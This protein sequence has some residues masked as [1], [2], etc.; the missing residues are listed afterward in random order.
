MSVFF[1]QCK[2]SA[3]KYIRDHLAKS[4]NTGGA[5]FTIRIRVRKPLQGVLIRIRMKYFSKD[6]KPAVF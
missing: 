3:Q 5:D 2:A 6:E 4:I 1:T